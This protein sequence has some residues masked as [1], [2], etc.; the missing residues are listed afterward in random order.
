MCYFLCKAQK[1]TISRGFNLISNSWQNPRWR[2]RW[3]LLLVTL[4][5]ST[6]PT[7]IKY[8]SS[9]QEDKVLSTKGKIVSKCG[10]ISKTAGRGFIHPNPPPPPPLSH[11]VVTNLRVHPR[12]KSI[13]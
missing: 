7:P 5:A 3:R 8:T 2:P 12:V 1:I 6:A 9:C 13:L 11:G 10:N 4:Q